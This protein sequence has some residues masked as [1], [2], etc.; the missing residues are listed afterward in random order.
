MVVEL[1]ELEGVDGE[2]ENFNSGFYAG[3]QD[4]MNDIKK[5]IEIAGVRHNGE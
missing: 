2:C 4:C 3:Y 5:S 1:P